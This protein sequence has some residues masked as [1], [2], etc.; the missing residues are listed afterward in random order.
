MATQAI[1]MSCRDPS[2]DACAV[3]R[4]AEHVWRAVVVVCARGGYHNKGFEF[5]L[6]NN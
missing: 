2:D 5:N 1:H 3:A 4:H 6:I